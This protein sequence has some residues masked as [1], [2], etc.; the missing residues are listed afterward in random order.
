M[1]LV[2]RVEVRLRDEP[3]TGDFALVQEICD[4]ASVRICLRVQ[5][6][7]LPELLLPIAADVAVKIWRRCNYEG[8]SSENKAQ[9]S[10]SFV[11][12][13][14]AE[15]DAEFEAYRLSRDQEDGTGRVRFL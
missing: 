2:E 11:E 7:A 13:I 5:E 1:T 9:I 4:L 3:G 6:T 8:I 12:D 10:T 14:L 15:Y